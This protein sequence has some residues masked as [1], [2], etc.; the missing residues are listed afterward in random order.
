MNNEGITRMLTILL[1]VML[2]VLFILVCVFLIL[3]LKK[4]KKQKSSQS[5]SSPSAP[6]KT[7]YVEQNYNKQSIFNFMEFDTIEDNMII[8]NKGKRFLMVIQCQGVNYDLMSKLEKNSVEAGFIEFLNSLR[9]PIQIYTQTRTVNLENTISNYKARVDEI[10]ERLERLKL[11]YSEMQKTNRYSEEQKNRLY[12]EITKQ[13]NLYEYAKDVIFNIEKM[14]L[15]KNVL[16]KNYYIVVPYYP[17]DLGENK[18][19]AEEIKG[20]AFSELYTKAQSVIRTLAGCSVNGKILSSNELVELLYIAY[21]RDEAEVYGVEKALRAGYDE[22]YS[23][24]PDVLDKRMK[25]LD[26]KIEKEALERAKE[27]L[28]RAKTE[29][30]KRVAEKEANL[31]SLISRM[32]KKIIETNRKNI[33]PEIAE[34]AMRNIDSKEE[35]EGG[36]TDVQ[37]TRKGRVRRSS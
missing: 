27:E 29:K 5:I 30:E 1:M 25:F 15:N 20:I 18:F 2:V 23:T 19:D 13:N 7:N 3:K 32:A 11:E 35:K 31:N 9:H 37:K 16:N 34:R 6:Q 21:N 33:D 4:N 28:Q 10:G 36:D 12:Y 14:S 26:E 8:Q 17:E 22:L 24:A